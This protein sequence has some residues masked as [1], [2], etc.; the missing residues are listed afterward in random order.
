MVTA[1]YAG[2]WGVCLRLTHGVAV[3]QE[4]SVG[5]AIPLQCHVVGVDTVGILLVLGE[6]GGE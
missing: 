4:D 2:T 1:V 3:Q 5:I 6:P